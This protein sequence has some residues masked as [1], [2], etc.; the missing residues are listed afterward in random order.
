[1]KGMAL[2]TVIQWII[3]IVV[4][5][6]I[7]NL[8]FFFSDEVKRV[9]GQFT[10]GEKPKTE[11]INSNVFSTSQIK[12]YMKSCWDKTGEKFQEDLTCYILRGDV[13]GVD[14]NSLMDIDYPANVDISNFYLDEKVTIIKFEDVGN[15]IILE[16]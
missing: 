3:L 12:T 10:K 2:E 15:K 11:T 8:I 16:S 9:I 5:G 14:P 4:A 13:N 7:F 6:V 1:M